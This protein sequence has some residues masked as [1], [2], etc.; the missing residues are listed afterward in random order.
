M[1]YIIAVNKPYDIPVKV[2]FGGWWVA[3]EPAFQTWIRYFGEPPY[4]LMGTWVLGWISPARWAEMFP[5]GPAQPP[6]G[7]IPP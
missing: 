4:L 1:V 5:F 7:P 3:W 2:P 6:A